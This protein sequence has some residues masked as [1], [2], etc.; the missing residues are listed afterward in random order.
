M[1]DIVLELKC[2]T[3]FEMFADD[4]THYTSS[5]TEHEND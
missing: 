1:N 5:I 4:S 2:S 3:E